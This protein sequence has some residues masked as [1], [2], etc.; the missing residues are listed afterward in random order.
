MTDSFKERAR[1]EYAEQKIDFM[2][3]DSGSAALG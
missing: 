3:D 2:I 1:D